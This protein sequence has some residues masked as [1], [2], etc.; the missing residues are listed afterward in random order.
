M[1]ATGA[2]VSFEC[3]MDKGKEARVPSVAVKKMQIVNCTNFESSTHDEPSLDGS[4]AK[5]GSVSKGKSKIV[6]Q[7]PEEYGISC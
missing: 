2:W 6:V 4:L 1:C 3:D 5:E 7:I